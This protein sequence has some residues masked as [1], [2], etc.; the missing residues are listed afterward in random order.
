M[1]EVIPLNIAITEL[2]KLE[3]ELRKGGVIVLPVEGSYVYVADAFNT[4]AVKKIHELRGDEEGIATSVVIGRPETLNGI[5]NGITAEISKIAEKFWPGLLTIYI[6]PNSALAWDLGDGGELGEFAVRI[7]NS[8]LLISLA[9]NIGPLAIASAANSGLG[10]ARNLD[11]VGALI[12]DINFYVDAGLLESA[13]LST[14]IRSKVIG[15]PELEV[16]RI[17][18]ISL[19]ELQG[20]VPGISMVE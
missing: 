15:L 6:Q 11:E 16:L 13:P 3:N 5:G 1:S 8:E 17:G 10:A 7:P 12:G 19:E 18:A 14:V 9:K 4:N 20:Q 2:A